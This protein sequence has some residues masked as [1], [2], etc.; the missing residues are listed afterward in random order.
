MC[1]KC[2]D[3]G[4]VEVIYDDGDYIEPCSVCQIEVKHIER[5]INARSAA[6]KDGYV[7]SDSGSV[8][9]FKFSEKKESLSILQKVM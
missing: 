1:R 4:Y 8:L 6:L 3:L 7:L 5:E 2:D 9:D